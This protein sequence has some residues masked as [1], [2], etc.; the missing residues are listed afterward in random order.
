MYKI[1][2]TVIA[3]HTKGFLVQDNTGAIL[4]FKKGHTLK[5][6]QDRNH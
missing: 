5:A 2:G 4:V 1:E 6:K 3:T